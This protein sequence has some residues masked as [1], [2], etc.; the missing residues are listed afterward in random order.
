MKQSFAFIIIILMTSCLGKRDD[1]PNEAI[2]TSIAECRI[3]SMHIVVDSSIYN[4]KSYNLNSYLS[5]NN[6]IYGYN[7][8][9]HAIDI[10]DLNNRALT[11]T[12]R[13]NSQGPDAVA[14]QVCGIDVIAPDSIVLY[15]GTAIC[16]INNDGLMTNRFELPENGFIQIQT[17]SRAAIAGFSIDFNTH[18][19]LYP[20]GHDGQ[21]EVL[22]YNFQSDSIEWRHQLHTP[23]SQGKYGFMRTPNITFDFPRIIYNYP[24]EKEVFVYDIVS[25]TTKIVNPE[26]N[27]IKD[28]MQPYNGSTIEDLTWYGIKNHFY[29][30]LYNMSDRHMY[31]RLALGGSKNGRKDNPETAM[32]NRPFYLMCFDRNINPVGEISLP[33]HRYDPFGGWCVIPNA[34]ALFRDNLFDDSKEDGITI[35]IIHPIYP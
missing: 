29:S 12:I 3:D 6:S 1:N 15:D 26:S 34:I 33:E 14:G 22:R 18:T 9:T 10:I 13:L 28:S 16:L 11:N 35:D 27:F 24:F 2:Y 4:L 5:K 19:I 23:V 20:I 7:Y 30:S 21:F 17:N 25:D 31:V 8:K 32:Q